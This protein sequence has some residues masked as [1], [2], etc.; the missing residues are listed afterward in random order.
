M[1]RSLYKL[2]VQGIVV[3]VDPITAIAYR[4]DTTEPVGHIVWTDLAAEPRLILNS[5][6]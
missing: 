4:Y 6:K 2:N 1:E 5:K 3:L